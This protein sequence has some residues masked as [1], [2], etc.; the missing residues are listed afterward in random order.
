[1]HRIAGPWQADSGPGQTSPIDL[2]LQ[3][4]CPGGRTGLAACPL[5]R[6]RGQIAILPV[7]LPGLRSFSPWWSNKGLVSACLRVRPYGRALSTANLAAVEVMNASAL[8]TRVARRRHHPS[9]RAE[10][11]RPRR[12]GPDRPPRCRPVEPDSRPE[13]GLSGST[14]ARRSKPAR[15]RRPE[16]ATGPAWGNPGVR[17]DGTGGAGAVGQSPEAG[18]PAVRPG[19]RV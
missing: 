2:R 13:R 3:T 14:K 18:R 12:R 19:D 9:N 15:S 7:R 10:P 1:M 5:A 4:D 6:P 17:F 16:Q 8:R 11:V